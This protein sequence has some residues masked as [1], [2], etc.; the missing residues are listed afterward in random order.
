MRTL[1][2]T[3]AGLACCGQML[4]ATEIS[5]TDMSFMTDQTAWIRGSVHDPSITISKDA[6]G[7]ETYYVFGSHMG[8][9]KT[10]DLKS[11]NTVTYE[12]TDSPLF[13]DAN[14]NTVSYENA[15]RTNV[16]KT[17]TNYAGKT[18]TFGN[19]DASA[20]NTSINNFTVAGNMWAPDVIYNPYLKKW[21]LY[22]SLNGAQWNSSIVLLTSDAIE[23]PYVYQ[24]PIVFSGF[25]VTTEAATDYKKTDMEIAL[26]SLSSLPS[27]YNVGTQWGTYWPH[28]IDP[29]VFFDENGELWMNYGSWSGGI[30][31]LKLDKKTG[32]R[33]YTYTYSSDY[34]SQ[35][36]SVTSDPYFG[37]KIAG[38]YYVSGE[39]SYIEHIG[40]YYYLFMSY[41]FY[42]PEGGYEM[43]IFRSTSP[44]GPYVDQAGV[45]AKYT[46]Y[47]MNYG[48]KAT[49][50]KGMKLMGGYLLD[51]MKVAEIAQ[52]HNSAFTDGYD[53]SMVIYHTKFNDGTAGHQLRA[54][55]LFVNT[56][57]WI[58][59]APYE[60]NSSA[61]NATNAGIKSKSYFTNSEIAGTYDL[62]I[63]KYKVDYENY[64]YSSPVSITL[65]TDGSV[66]GAYTG[67]WKTTNGTAYITL[68][69]GGTT[70]NG[71]VIPQSVSESNIPAIGIT[72]MNSTSGVNV[73][74]TKL[75]DKGFIAKEMIALQKIINSGDDVYADLNLPST[76]EGGCVLKW[77]SS[78]EDVVSNTGAVAP[79]STDTNVTLTL[80]ISKGDYTYT[81]DY[82]ITVKANGLSGTDIATGIVAYYNFDNNLIN[83]YS[84]SQVGVAG[85]LSSGTAPTYET[86]AERNSTVWHQ[87]FG[88]ADVKTTSYTTFTNPLAGQTLTGA[89]VSMWVNRL[90]SDVW[91]ALWSFCSGTFDDITGRLY[92]TGNTYLGI[93][94]NGAWM[95]YNH[96]SNVT[97]NLIPTATWSLVT[98]SFT[99]DGFDIYVD[100]K[101]VGDQATYKAYASSGAVTGQNML[102]LM[103]Q[104]SNFYLGY[105]SF[106]GSTPALFDDLLIYNRALNSVEVAKLYWFETNGVSL[107]PN[108]LSAVPDTAVLIK[109]GAGKS[110][111]TVYQD[112]ALVNFY[113]NYENANS[114]IVSGLPAGVTYTIDATAKT[115]TFEGVVTAE[116][117]DYTWTITT[118]GANVNVSKGGIITVRS[119]STGVGQTEADKESMTVTPNPSAGEVTV[120]VKAERET[121]AMLKVMNLAGQ[122]CYSQIVSLK[123]GKNVIPMSLKLNAGI[124]AVMVDGKV[125]RMVVK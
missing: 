53:H 2:V 71:E 97:T 98:L 5:Q 9:A 40:N 96:P 121:A 11:W 18:V 78:A 44:D 84:T 38:G 58:T 37:K 124:Y 85:A 95:D 14:G 23:G 70:Y 48:T 77:T 113:Y 26:G 67:T 24:G 51:G 52:G 112:S 90:D 109:H 88:Y 55:Q 21:C 3:L 92:L 41:G 28:A 59:A 10:T 46:K 114:V 34:D 33:D 116:P 20:W 1:I 30:Y 74:A 81:Q 118:T 19:F 125:C 79:R 86:N 57:G 69:I 32:L 15:F 73:W 101:K 75:S 64:E 29:G 93:N 107:M 110:T 27:R 72:A 45:D 31:V 43:R 102:T 89:T 115:V 36:A 42:S 82:D 54:H 35:K 120:C 13:G 16:V 100:G 4:T 87:Y 47:L 91:D 25:N 117:G 49:T 8:V 66:S 123:A 108:D 106:W 63:H 103:S 104:A 68:T 65:N 111:Q 61:E 7:N 80:N 119:T 105:G 99:A 39:G 76:G 83:Q 17:V 50:N 122:T 22:F 56:D 12:T 60:F 62:I 6:S 94:A